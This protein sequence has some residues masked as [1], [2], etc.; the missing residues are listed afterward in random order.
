MRGDR[1]ILDLWLEYEEGETQEA[2]IV[3]QLDK[4]DAA[5]QAIEYEKL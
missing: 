1:E 3:K 5:I 4:L 2:K